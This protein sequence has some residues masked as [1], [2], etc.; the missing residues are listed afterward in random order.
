MVVNNVEIRC[1]PS[2]PF[3]G[4]VELLP[5]LQVIWK[6]RMILQAFFTDSFC[7]FLY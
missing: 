3:P 4:T 1:V 5:G 2:V 6:Q 7:V